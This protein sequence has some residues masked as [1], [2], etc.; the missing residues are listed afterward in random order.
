M[1][2]NELHSGRF[3]IIS[4]TN[5][6]L[7]AAGQE[8]IEALKQSH[9]SS[10]EES[11]AHG[12]VIMSVLADQKRAVEGT[13]LAVEHANHVAEATRRVERAQNAEVDRLKAEVKVAEAQRLFEQV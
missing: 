5:A 12:R 13:E 6:F 9:N 2:C 7:L 4:N 11:E 10:V 3:T 8:R 1:D